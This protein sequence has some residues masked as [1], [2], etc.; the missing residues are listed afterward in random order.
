MTSILVAITLAFSPSNTAIRAT[1]APE[2]KEVVAQAVRVATCESSGDPYATNGQYLGLF[3]LGAWARSRY[4]H[5]PWY[6]GW[7]NARAARALW[8][9]NGRSWRGQ[10]ECAW[11]A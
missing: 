10:W 1:F 5:G 3:Q 2:G 6:S 11:A 4:L 7:A 9:A 8:R